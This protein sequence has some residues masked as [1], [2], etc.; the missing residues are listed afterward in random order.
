MTQ[1][2]QEAFMAAYE[3]CHEPFLRYCSVLAWGRMDT[4]DLVQDVLL[5]AYHHFDRVEDPAQLLHYLIRAARNRSV[6]AWRRRK[7]RERYLAQQ[8]RRL[9]ARG[10]SPEVQA[11]I[12][13]LYRA[14]DHL[15]PRQREALVLFE[16][17]GFSMKEI[18]GIQGSSV[19]AVKT[20]V[21]RGRQ[22]L[23]QL[24]TDRVSAPS[25][26]GLLLTLKSLTL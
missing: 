6:S 8:A 20:R 13:L 3:S 25:L 24:L 12:H 21:S 17:S 11:D 5:S 19:A 23:R 15:P 14:I 10:V 2:K 1:Q 26:D 4:E 18:A 7:V 9:E 16:I 22:R